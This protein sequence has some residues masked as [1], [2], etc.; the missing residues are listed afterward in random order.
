[1]EIWAI[2]PSCL[3]ALDFEA[4]GIKT[5]DRFLQRENYQI[6]GNTA[7]IPVKGILQLNKPAKNGENI[8]ALDVVREQLMDAVKRKKVY[9]IVLNIDSPGGVV[10]GVEALANFI[11]QIRDQKEII[12]VV[13]STA[14]SAAYWIA[15]ACSQVIMSSKTS[16]AGNVGVIIRHRDI[17]K[18]NEMNGV[19]VTAI[20][21]AKYK[22]AGSPFR[23]LTE[24]DSEILSSQVQ[25]MHNVFVAAVAKGRNKTFQDV[26]NNIA[27]GKIFVGEEAVLMG[28]AD[29]IASIDEVLAVQ[30]FN[31]QNSIVFPNDGDLQNMEITRE[32]L[33]AKAQSIVKSIKEEAVQEF[34]ATQDENTAKAISAER[35]RIAKISAIGCDES[36]KQSAIANG[37]EYGAFCI[38]VVEAGGPMKEKSMDEKY[39]EKSMKEKSMKE[40][41]M[42]DKDKA[43]DEKSMDDKEKEKLKSQIKT[44]QEKL[45][46]MEQ[47]QKASAQA[48]SVVGVGGV[49]ASASA[50]DAQANMLS[51]VRGER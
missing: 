6:V 13:N 20:T 48:P 45:K 40:K 50:N 41:S 1:M 7:I 29:Q 44:M 34:K 4:R 43:M 18:Q 15:S 3:D 24:E 39:K 14:A 25:A 10:D 22:D 5:K 26:E 23:E 11:Y 49:S 31:A 51:I 9:S 17:S 2:D 36:L 30:N 28:L 16:K 12:A 46:A 35:E 38:S 8:T 27:N 33:N 37:M 32:L 47:K 21:S 19:K 42:G